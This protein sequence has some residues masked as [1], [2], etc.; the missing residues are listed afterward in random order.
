MN[1]QCVTIQMKAFEKCFDLVLFI[2]LYKIL[3]TSLSV[4]GTLLRS[5]FT[6][7]CFLFVSLLYFRD[8]CLIFLAVMV[9]IGSY[10]R[11][12]M[13]QILCITFILFFFWYK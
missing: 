8:S 6:W 7:L 9:I 11:T 2:M 10:Y 1:L 12:Y 3:L 13:F 4:N 5:A